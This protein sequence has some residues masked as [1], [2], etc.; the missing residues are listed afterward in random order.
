MTQP[1]LNP[2]QRKALKGWAHHLKPLM[3]LGK[4]GPTEAFLVALAE[5]LE[6]HELL[7]IRIL[8][9]CSVSLSELADRFQKIDAQVVQKVGRIV[10]VFRQREE[11]S[12][13]RLPQ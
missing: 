2:K 4:E 6:T 10:T 8:K 12:A 1:P 13:F 11:D 7:K 9:S 3:Q 5:H